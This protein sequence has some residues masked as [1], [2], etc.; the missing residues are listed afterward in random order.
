M[1]EEL[2]SFV[3]SFGTLKDSLLACLKVDFKI[4]RQF[5]ELVS[6][7]NLDCRRLIKVRCL[8]L[9]KLETAKERKQNFENENFQRQHSKLATSSSPLVALV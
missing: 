1:F 9:I 6:R 4:W 3:T 2:P 7:I 5:F 8:I